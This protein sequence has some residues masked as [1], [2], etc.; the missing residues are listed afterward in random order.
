MLCRHF[1]ET[2]A[3]PCGHCTRCMGND[4]AAPPSQR[5]ASP[6]DETILAEAL[7]R[8]TSQSPGALRPG[9]HDPLAL[10]YHL[11][12]TDEVQAFLTPAIRRARAPVILG[13]ARS[14]RTRSGNLERELS[15]RQKRQ[16]GMPDAH[17][18]LCGPTRVARPASQAASTPRRVRSK[19][20]SWVTSL[21]PRVLIAVPMGH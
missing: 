11:A 19:K 7:V 3:E 4:R 14:A 9:C 17:K 8:P 2:R 16:A 5:S 20:P 18:Y 10:R 12:G 13:S 21:R 15:A 1:G 6:L